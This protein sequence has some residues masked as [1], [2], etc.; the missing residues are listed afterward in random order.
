MDGDETAGRAR[1]AVRRARR[2]G[3]AVAAPLLAL[4]LLTGCSRQK[5]VVT[6]TM[7]LLDAAIAE[8]YASKDIQ[9]A[10][11]GIPA[12]LMLLRGLC[13][14]DPDR[15]ET[16]TTTVELYTSYAMLFI[17]EDDPA[18]ALDLYDEG[19]DLGLRF[20]RRYDWFARAWDAG[21]DA[22]RAEIEQRQP[23]DLGPIMMWTGACLG[24]H[25][26]QNQEHPREMLDL[27][28]VQVLLDAAI[29]LSGDYFHGMPYAAKGMVMAMIP[30]GLGGNLEASDRYFEKALES[31]GRRFLLHQVLYARYRC[32]AGLDEEAFARALQ[33]V[34]DAP[35]DVMPEMRFANRLA[36][37]RARLLLDHRAQFF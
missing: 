9:T 3:F 8:T 34:L 11:A 2:R 23:R 16:W 5:L 29:D 20:L 24:Q 35:D 4:L 10:R 32:V 22:L 30:L 26:L 36:K 14:N 7:P 15:V 31:S 17:A 6:A 19:K 12:Q 13:R 21:P 27:P 25:V 37:E 18:W 33:E 1:R 28:N